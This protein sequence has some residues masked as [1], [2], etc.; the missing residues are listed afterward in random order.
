MGN[1]G[2]DKPTLSSARHPVTAVMPCLYPVFTLFAA[3]LR[4]LFGGFNMHPAPWSK[5]WGAPRNHA[6]EI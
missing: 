1:L 5:P 2:V 6:A 3:H 4:R